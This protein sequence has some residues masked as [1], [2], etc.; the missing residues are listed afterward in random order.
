MEARAR[1]QIRGAMSSNKLV[2]W[3]YQAAVR[4]VDAMLGEKYLAEQPEQEKRTKNRDIEHM[5][6]LKPREDGR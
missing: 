6:Q 4:D 1:E 5:V 3:R 2:F